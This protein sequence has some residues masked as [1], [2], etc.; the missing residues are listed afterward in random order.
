MHARCGQDLE[1]KQVGQKFEVVEQ[2]K[3]GISKGLEPGKLM[4][5]CAVCWRAHTL[6]FSPSAVNKYRRCKR[7]YAF[8]YNEKIKLPPSEKQEFGLEVHKKLELWLKKEEYPDDSPAGLVARQSID[9]GW[10]PKPNPKL[11]VEYEFEFPVVEFELGKT[12]GLSGFGYIDCVVPPELT[13]AEPMVIDHKSTSDLRWA[14]T[15][16]ELL[17]DPQSL[18]YSVWAMLHFNVPKVRARWIYYAASNPQDGSPREPRGVKPVE[19]LI[20]NQ[21]AMV[22]SAIPE[23]LKDFTA[24]AVIRRERRIGLSFDPTPES[25]GMYG[26]CPHIERCNLTPGDRLASYIERGY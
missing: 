17:T 24:M 6:F 1:V 18:I 4:D 22:M 7:L 14:M 16:E 21:D 26:G 13:G 8:E 15:E 5:K 11:L 20:S 23:I 19:V 12:K 10:L 3:E 2:C 9:K 25:C